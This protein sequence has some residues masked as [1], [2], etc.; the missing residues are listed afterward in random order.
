MPSRYRLSSHA[1]ADLVEIA[2]YIARDNLDAALRHDELLHEKFAALA[3]NP[4][5]GRARD[6]MRPGLRSLPVGAYLIYYAEQ[7]DWVEV[8]RVVHA[9]RDPANWDLP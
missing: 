9:A 6:S 3:Q 2:V 1:A 4:K 7:S 8:V 5:L